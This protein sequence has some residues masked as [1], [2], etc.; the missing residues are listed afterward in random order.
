MSRSETVVI[1]VGGSLIVPSGG[2]GTPD[3]K[4]LKNLREFVAHSVALGKR[5]VLIAGGGKTARQYQNVLNELVE[6][7]SDDQDWIGIH[8]TRL[9]GQLLKIALKGFAEEFLI[10]NPNEL[11]T[12][13][14]PVM[15]GG[16]YKPG[17]STD[18]RAVQVAKNLGA[19]KVIN[20]SN[21]DYAYTADPNEDPDAKKIET[22][23]WNEFLSLVP[24]E[25][26]PG[27]ST[28]FDPIASRE[29]KTNGIEVAIIN[30]NKLEEVE[31]YLHG[32][33]FIGSVIK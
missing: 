27:L 32:K 4:F 20:L 23:S 15:V 22:M 12:T 5:L 17:S 2:D 3:A 30:G 33:S 31:K 26:S 7:N 21:I 10:T 9:N 28:P 19:T 16:G 14:K 1:S 18:L 6:T 25:W 13:D 29:A 11:P 8:A 24:H